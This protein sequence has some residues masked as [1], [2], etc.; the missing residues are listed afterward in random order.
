[1]LQRITAILLLGALVLGSAPSASAQSAPRGFGPTVR[2]G[3]SLPSQEAEAE[4][5]LRATR[6]ALR[7]QARQALYAAL[8]DPGTDDDAAA[9]Q[10]L[11][12]VI[13]DESTTSGFR[14]ALQLQ[15]AAL[16]LYRD[17][18][19]QADQTLARA[20]RLAGESRTL[21]QSLDL[22]EAGRE[23]LDHRPER[24]RQLLDCP[25]S[26]EHNQALAALCTP[27]TA[28]PP[29]ALLR[30]EF[31]VAALLH[32]PLDDARD[33]HLARQRFVVEPLTLARLR[34][35]QAPAHTLDALLN[36]A[37]T[38]NDN[39]AELR[40]QLAR[41]RQLLQSEAAPELAA[42]ALARAAELLPALQDDF[43]GLRLTALQA[44]SCL[45]ERSP[46]SCG[47]TAAELTALTTL[48]PELLPQIPWH[49]HCDPALGP[50]ALPL[51]AHAQTLG[52]PER[53][54][55][56]TLT[57]AQIHLERFQPAL[58][59]DA[60]QGLEDFIGPAPA[61]P[62]PLL[63]D[64]CH[65]HERARSAHTYQAC[66]QALTGLADLPTDLD[67]WALRPGLI[68]IHQAL[69]HAPPQSTARATPSDHLRLAIDLALAGD[70]PLYG[71][72]AV[73]ALDRADLYARRSPTPADAPAYFAEALALA[74]RAAQ[75]PERSAH[76]QVI[77]PAQLARLHTRWLASL[78][79][80]KLWEDLLTRA[81]KAY[82]L[83]R[84]TSDPVLG[85]TAL[86]RRAQAHLAL[87][88]P[89]RAC[90]ALRAAQALG[91]PPPLQELA[92]ELRPH[93]LEP[94]ALATP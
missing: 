45:Q 39:A 18:P 51:C 44:Q 43:A 64:R 63:V 86:M 47:D 35:R 38:R 87:Q 54:A 85:A 88:E 90:S 9:R 14:I 49:Q 72:A 15:L 94:P 55:R 84:T 31:F 36:E 59:R 23:L 91:T 41:A 48:P 78:A 22:F 61:L 52:P 66:T 81:Q 29:A 79:A 62:A 16:H 50:A 73:A 4:A 83:A 69:A 76:D 1:M 30:R 77:S 32:R 7:E 40:L 10:T 11:Q 27:D 58:A 65:L 53:R 60:L 75:S 33:T 13:D 80:L 42:H 34:A 12:R 93:C 25:S 37:R 57:R 26:P 2:I 56:A 67:T 68:L 17:R 24:A 82:L 21:L 74:Q 8:T 92:S 70:R 5:R 19:E 20:R 28:L 89:E 6:A 3:G 46:A 71:L